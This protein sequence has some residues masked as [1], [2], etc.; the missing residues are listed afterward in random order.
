MLCFYSIDSPTLERHIHEARGI[1][2]SVAIRS[3]VTS[4]A[5][6]L[7]EIIT[8][9]K[10]L[11]PAYHKDFNM[12]FDAYVDPIDEVVW[13]H[14]VP[15]NWEASIDDMKQ[16]ARKHPEIEFVLCTADADTLIECREFFLGD[17]YHLS[18]S[19]LRFEKAP[20]WSMTEYNDEI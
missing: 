8:S 7:Y 2:K 12:N 19:F 13:N 1:A 16:L 3:L 15:W 17:K 18:N 14:N 9:H 11:D 5:R 10:D 20:E 6:D 4:I